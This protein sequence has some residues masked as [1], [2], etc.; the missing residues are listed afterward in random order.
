MWNNLKEKFQKHKLFYIL[1]ITLVLL[2]GY[3]LTT[4]WLGKGWIKYCHNAHLELTN[5]NSLFELCV[6]FNLAYSVALNFRREVKNRFYDTVHKLLERHKDRT[7]QLLLIIPRIQNEKNV[8]NL[9]SYIK[10]I[11][12]RKNIE[13]Q[14]SE[15]VSKHRSEDIFLYFAFYSLMCL[16]I[17]PIIDGYELSTFQGRAFSFL[18]LFTIITVF[19]VELRYVFLR[20]NK[21]QFENVV[22]VFSS[23]LVVCYSLIKWIDISWIKSIP[24]PFELINQVILFIIALFSNQSSSSSFEKNIIILFCVL[25]NIYPFFQIFRG[26]FYLSFKYTCTSYYVY[27]YAES[28]YRTKPVRLKIKTKYNDIK[29]DSYTSWNNVLHKS[30]TFISR[31]TS[32]R[33]KPNDS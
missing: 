18:L 9:S 23:N 1:L 8:Q 27:I 21:P 4:T 24:K 29:S 26:F 33:E 7:L 22:I 12:D 31:V 6:T 30:K 32:K 20:K 10:D 16:I 28:D 13:K 17:G 15:G 2:G 19:L 3:L 11:I 14:Y 25:L 5:F